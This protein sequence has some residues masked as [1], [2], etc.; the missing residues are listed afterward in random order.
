[1]KAL[2]VLMGVGLIVALIAYSQGGG[3][4]MLTSDTYAM[5]MAF[6]NQYDDTIE[7]Q[8]MIP[9]G[10]I[11]KDPRELKWVNGVQVLETWQEWMP[12]HFN[13]YDSTGEIVKWRRYSTSGMIPNKDQRGNIEFF[14]S[15]R[16]TPGESYTLDYQPNRHDPKI[17]RYEFTAP[18]EDKKLYRPTFNVAQPE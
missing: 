13:I 14:L 12:K 2:S 11:K 3:G 4:G 10:V 5:A 1:M 7:M 9:G 17:Y 18:S 6:G 15:W 8:V 16:V